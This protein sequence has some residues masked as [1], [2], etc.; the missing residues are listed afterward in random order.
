MFCHLKQRTK[1]TP[2]SIYTSQTEK[3][4]HATST[5]ATGQH[6]PLHLRSA[7]NLRAKGWLHGTHCSA[8]QPFPVGYLCLAPA[9][10]LPKNVL[11]G[12]RRAR[13]RRKTTHGPACSL[14]FL[15][16]SSVGQRS[17]LEKPCVAHGRKAI[18]S[19]HKPRRMGTSTE[20]LPVLQFQASSSSVV[21]LDS[22]SFEW[23][24]GN[25]TP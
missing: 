5:L 18:S 25:K 8:H 21:L 12:S 14:L 3:S 22:P 9:R 6:P 4:L 1:C 10:H 15:P 11:Q 20:P 19:D 16:T 24:P 13:H 7:V 2:S 17:S 23:L